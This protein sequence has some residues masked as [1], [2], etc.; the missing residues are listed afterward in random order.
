M[1][2]GTKFSDVFQ[3]AKSAKLVP[4]HN[5]HLSGCQRLENE[6]RKMPKECNFADL[7]GIFLEL[8][9]LLSLPQL[10]VHRELQPAPSG[11]LPERHV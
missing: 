2:A 1:F 3:F 4:A 11:Q 8:H 7:L 5:S 6:A 9:S 10:L